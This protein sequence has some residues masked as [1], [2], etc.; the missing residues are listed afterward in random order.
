ML[1]LGKT[2]KGEHETVAISLIKTKLKSNA[3]NLINSEKNI[4]EIIATLTRTVKGESVEVIAAKIM[5]VRQNSKTAN[6]YCNEIEI[7]TKSLENAYI[8]DGLPVELAGKYSTQTAVRAI[9]FTVLRRLRHNGG[10]TFQQ[11]E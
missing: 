11:Y 9:I 5:N 10:R 4:S 8:S 2:I 1:S 7:L 3:R 6:N